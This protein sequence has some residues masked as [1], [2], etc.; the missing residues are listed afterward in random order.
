MC[1]PATGDADVFGHHQAPA[2]CWHDWAVGCTG[3][4]R[5]TVERYGRAVWIWINGHPFVVTGRHLVSSYQE[6]HRRALHA[7]QSVPCLELGPVIVCY[8]RQYRCIFIRLARVG[9]RRVVVKAMKEQ[10]RVGLLDL[11]A[12]RHKVSAFPKGWAGACVEQDFLRL[13]HRPSMFAGG[14]YRHG[15]A[16][17]WRR[18]ITRACFSHEHLSRGDDCCLICV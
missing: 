3:H 5:P 1:Q 15:Y 10:G 18:R 14:L 8:R 17:W 4:L 6:A 7:P 2:R 11:A 12:D 9:T 16:E 13:W